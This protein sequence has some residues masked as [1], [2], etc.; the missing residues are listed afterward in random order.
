VHRSQPARLARLTR[1]A[2]AKEAAL[3]R[4]IAEFAN[5]R[6]VRLRDLVQETI[7]TLP[8]ELKAAES[9]AEEATAQLSEWDARQQF[10]EKMLLLADEARFQ[11]RDIT[12]A[13]MREMI[14][15]LDLRVDILESGLSLREGRPCRVRR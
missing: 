4:M 8:H 7:R 6:D 15:V 12:E 2:K 11:L 1:T 9:E 14:Q 10:I 3:S 13:E 5:E